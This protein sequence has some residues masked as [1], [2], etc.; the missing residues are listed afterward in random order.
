[1]KLLNNVLNV[2]TKNTFGINIYV[3]QITVILNNYIKYKMRIVKM[4][5]LT[6]V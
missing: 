6:V 4:F 1:M 2:Q 3:N 5:V